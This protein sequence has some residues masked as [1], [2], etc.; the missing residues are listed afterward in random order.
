MQATL[1]HLSAANLVSCLIS[2]N[3]SSNLALDLLNGA[4]AIRS[5]YSGSQYSGRMQYCLCVLGVGPGFDV[6]PPFSD[7]DGC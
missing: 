5:Q 6:P 7:H 4:G 2:G 1:D 3:T